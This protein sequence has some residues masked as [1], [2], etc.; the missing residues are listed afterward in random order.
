MSER[1][2]GMQQELR[3]SEARLQEYREQEQLIDVNGLRALPSQEINDLS[4]RLLEVRQTRAAAE[5]AHRQITAA[6]R[7]SDLQGV[8]AILEDEGIARFQAAQ[9]E[10]Q[11]AVAE[12]EKRYGPMHPRLIA[13]QSELARATENLTNQTRSVTEGIRNR[14][15]AARSEEASIEAALD[16]ARQ[17]YQDVGRKESELNNLQRVVDTNRQLYDLFYNRLSETSATG[18]LATAQARI[19]APAV[20]PGTAA[21]PS[22][23]RIVL[24]ATLL[25]VLFGVGVALLLESLDNTVRNSADVEARLKRPTLGMLP[26]LKG[27][28]LEAVGAIGA[29]E[30]DPRFG[31]AI[32]TVRTAISLDNLDKPHKV[33]LVTSALGNEGKSTFALNLAA[34]FAQSEKT[35]LLDADLRRPAIGKML[36]LRRDTPGL[37]ELLSEQARLMQCLTPLSGADL[38]VMSTGFIP[39]DPLQLLSSGRMAK[40]LKVL[41]HAYSRVIIDSPPILPVSDAAVLSKY[42]DAVLFVVK[43]DATTVAQIKS[44]LGLLERVNAPI[45]G[46]VLNQ[47]D[48]RKQSD[49][50]Y[51]GSYEPY[52]SKSRVA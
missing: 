40:A 16:R 24:I 4:S 3:A 45:T 26:L 9:A 33:I 30:I 11:Q 31:E 1:L 37:S 5:I 43:A 51:V 41:S 47:F 15:E 36:G 39:P 19:V 46:I 18:D 28:A 7:G 52:A 13:A 50:G 44:G 23:G 17:Q 35:L 12:L 27:K 10:A 32:R 22:K 48:Y 29:K 14:Y 42:A 38:V 20:V 8:P 21:K 34:A 49:Y 6:G 25:T 2:E